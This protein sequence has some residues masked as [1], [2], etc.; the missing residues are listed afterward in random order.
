[1]FGLLT[2]PAHPRVLHQRNV[3]YSFLAM[4]S[5]VWFVWCCIRYFRCCTMASSTK[6]ASVPH[7][8]VIPS[9]SLV[10]VFLF[11]FLSKGNRWARCDQTKKHLKTKEKTTRQ[12][13]M[14]E[15]SSPSA[16][17]S[18]SLFKFWLY[19][20]ADME[21]KKQK[22]TRTS[23]SSKS[24]DCPDVTNF[25]WVFL[26]SCAPFE[27]ATCCVTTR[28]G[29]DGESLDDKRTTTWSTR[30]PIRSSSSSIIISFVHT[31]SSYRR[32]VERKIENMIKGPM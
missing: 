12:K 29:G 4:V 10:R 13:R 16:A 3:R 28:T 17:F 32:S 30:R 9:I 25:C 26:F 14:R 27:N 23:K 6:C 24:D 1:M 15:I 2:H 21:R 8:D 7:V 20:N 31:T 11:G 18:S 5:P 22:K 19:R